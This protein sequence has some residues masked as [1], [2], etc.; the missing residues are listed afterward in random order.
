MIRLV[1]PSATW[2]DHGLHSRGS[3]EGYK[4]ISSN[5]KWLYTHG[6]QKWDVYYS[7]EAL[8]CQKDF[9]DFYLKDIDNGFDQK[10]SVRLEV[11][12]SLDKYTVRYEDSWP[13]RNTDYQKLYLNSSF[14]SLQ[15][16]PLPNS[17]TYHY[18]P[19][20]ENASFVYKFDKDTELTG[21]MK[22]KLWVSTNDGK[23]MDLFVGIKKLDVM[24][25][26][27]SFYAKTGY[28]KGPVAMGWLRVSERE[29][30]MEKSTAWQPVLTHKNPQTLAENQIVPV[31]IEILPSSTLFKN[32]ES[33]QV[34]IQGKDLFIHP[35]LGHHYSVNKGQHII[36]TGGKYDSHLLIPVVLRE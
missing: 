25:K 30:D 3:F 14:E 1:D 18:E 7:E 17:N 10:P 27:V 9:F 4:Q 12:E 34:I 23:D 36:Y 11:R 6:R 33:L 32:S 26:E 24:G 21:N 15:I 16:N 20:S 29:L 8:S 35:S 13:L 31:E 28:K 19:Y 22:L 2:S 5:N